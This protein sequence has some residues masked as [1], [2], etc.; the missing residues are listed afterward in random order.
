MDIAKFLLFISLSF[1]VPGYIAVRGQVK[2]WLAKIFISLVL[3]I[4]LFTLTSYLSANLNMRWVPQ[5]LVVLVFVFFILKKF[6]RDFSGFNFRIDKLGL[7]LLLLI[8]A[9]TFFQNS[10]TFKS[11]LSSDF[12]IGFWG[13]LGRDGIWHQ[14]LTIELLDHFPPGNPAFAGQPL[15]N[16]HYFYNLLIAETLRITGIPIAGLIYRFFP[17]LFSLMLGIGSYLLA[18]NLFGSR[19][20]SFLAVFLVYFGGS[21]GWLAEWLKTGIARGGESAFWANQPV[22]FNLNPPFAVSLIIFI[23]VVL[24]LKVFLDK[25]SFLSGASLALLSGSLT[26]FKVYAGV[27]VLGALLVISLKEF[28]EKRFGFFIWFL[29]ALAISLVV[30]LPQNSGASGLLV[31]SPFWLVHSMTDFADRVG[32]VKLSQAREAYFSGRLW[33]KFFLVEALGLFLFVVG[34]LGTRAVAFLGLPWMMKQGLLKK[35]EHLF[36]AAAAAISLL[37]SLLFVQKGNPWN[38]IQFVYYF[39][40]IAAIYAGFFVAKLSALLPKNL[41]LALLV[42]FILLTPLSPFWTFASGF[43][44]MPPAYLSYSEKN[45]L[46]FLGSQEE[47]VVLTLPFSEEVRT[48]FQDPYP[49]FTYASNTYVSAFSGQRTYLEDVE[50]QI[51]LQA[52]YEGR[53]AA[54]KEFFY[55]RNYSWGR[56]FLRSEN[57]SYIY[58]P[59]GFGILPNEIDLEIRKIYENPEVDIYEVVGI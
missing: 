5:V 33:V 8:L 22:S 44:T 9:G 51:I 1:F 11:G 54:I 59:K 58:L 20:A 35:G 17:I 12:G 23:G 27:I 32:W 19:K 29:A 18:Q 25:P 28:W 49:L 47:G 3:G 37:A 26:Q 52:D 30:F 24:A 42:I 45:A 36:L 46:E 15:Y 50:Q 21:F 41:F 14:A 4:V 40:Y 6:Y 38:T 56:E 7:V 43:S 31:F 16:Y 55:G 57:I 48:R 2:S 39:L 10:I 34:N 53:F 13:P